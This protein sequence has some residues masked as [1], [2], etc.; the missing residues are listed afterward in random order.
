MHMMNQKGFLQL[1]KQRTFIFDEKA[2]VMIPLIKICRNVPFII[3][4][5]ATPY[6]FEI[7]EEYNINFLWY[8]IVVPIE[9]LASE[10]IRRSGIGVVKYLQILLI[11]KPEDE[12]IND[13]ISG[14]RRI[15]D[16]TKKIEQG[17]KTG[18]SD[19]SC[20]LLLKIIGIC[21]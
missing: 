8:F 21:C 14:L 4:I 6:I 18:N 9:I 16:I 5:L 11:S 13:V 1:K 17:Q 19:L 20:L 3:V 7:L 2:D 10:L 15:K 12:Q